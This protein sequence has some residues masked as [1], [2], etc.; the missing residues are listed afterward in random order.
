MGREVRMVPK[1]WEHPVDEDGRFIPLFNGEEYQDDLTR[2][3][4]HNDK[5]N[6]GLRDDYAG[7]WRPR[8]GSEGCDNYSEWDGDKPA[9]DEYMPIFSSDEATC[10]MMYETCSE[11]TPISPAFESPEELAKWLAESNASAFGNMTASYGQW[12]EMINAKWAPSM[13][14]CGSIMRSGVE[15]MATMK[16]GATS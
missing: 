7:G 2:W 8:D 11:G 4:L 15:A 14:L 1:D 9:A 13:V 16:K 12:L 5:W 6:D 10:L 3:N